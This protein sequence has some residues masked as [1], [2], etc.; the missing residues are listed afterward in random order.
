MRV[1]RGGKQT[2][3]GNRDEFAISGESVRANRHAGDRPGS[4][5]HGY[6]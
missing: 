1:N 6:L 2:Q 4:P 3:D 5:E